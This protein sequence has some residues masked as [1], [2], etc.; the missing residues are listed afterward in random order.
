MKT[1]QVTT[2]ACLTD[3]MTISNVRRDG[4]VLPYGTVA[5]QFQDDKF[6]ILVD[7][8]KLGDAVLSVLA[9]TEENKDNG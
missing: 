5:L 9:A 1:V 7:L 4:V 3:T 8:G 2:D 6:E